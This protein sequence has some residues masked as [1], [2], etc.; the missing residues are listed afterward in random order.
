M[1][2]ADINPKVLV[3]CPTSDH[4]EYCLADYAAGIKNLTYKKFDVLL[5]D[6][7]K[8]DKYEGKI[9]A[10]NLPV[11][12][13]PFSE[14]TKDRV[15]RARNL[16]REKVI[17]GDYDYFLSL[18]QDVIPP[19]NIVEGLLRHNKSIVSAVVY[20][21][22]PQK[23]SK[24]WI[25]KP[26]LA[27]KS[28]S[29]QGKLAFLTAKQIEN[30]NAIVKVD[31]C[32]M[33]CLLISRKVLE[34]IKFRYEE[35]KYKTDNP[36]EVK[37]DDWCFCEDAQK[38]GYEIFADLGAEC[39]HLVLGGY[40]ITLGDTSKFVIASGEVSLKDIMKD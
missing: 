4:K 27:V 35:F 31:Y 23:Q 1:K 21:I 29:I 25:E 40:N 12:R 9:N 17:E 34:K 32:P 8:D 24:E 6:N 11:V 13:S 33:G 28:Q 10:L 14:Y 15:I 39:R 19:P 30:I 5:V 22:F 3:G 16:L 18:E 7:S 20:H 2:M 38:E 26:L 36:D 37:W